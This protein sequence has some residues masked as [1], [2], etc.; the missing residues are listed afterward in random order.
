[1]I[2]AIKNAQVVLENRIIWDGVILLSDD[3]IIDYGRGRDIDIPQDAKVIDANG[4]YVGPGFVDIHVHGG[5]GLS[6]CFET[7][8]AAEYFLKYGTTS[9]LA[10]TDYHM[11]KDRMLAAIESIKKAAETTPTLRGIYME[12]PLTN[13]EYGS[14]ASENPWRG[15][16]PQDLFMKIADA[17]GDFVKVWTIAPEREGLLPALE[18]ARKVNPNVVFAIGHSEA[19]PEQIRALGIYKPTL[20]THAMCATGRVPCEDGTRGYGP[21]EYCM[22]EK[23][24]YCELISDSY[25]IHVNYDIQQMMVNAKGVERMILITDSSIHKCVNPE[26]LSHI[27]DLNFDTNGGLAGTKLTMDKVCQNIMCGTSCGITQAF[28]MASTNPARAIGMGNEIG[29]IERGKFADLVFVDDKFNIKNV[30][31][32]GKLCEF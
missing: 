13:P 30:M 14:F 20:E 4:A 6:I 19:T 18:Y 11:D 1:M 9:I 10:G 28:Q 8:K 21:D 5:N 32:R 16:I 27:T 29:S 2:T 25:G 3:K 26:N 23:E 12:G 17:G 22:A 15:V 31:L 7:E 24:V